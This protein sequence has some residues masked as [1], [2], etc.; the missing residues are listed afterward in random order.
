MEQ[1]LSLD[2]PLWTWCTA[3]QERKLAKIGAIDKLSLEQ[4]QV[5]TTSRSMSL[6]CSY[7]DSTIAVCS[8]QGIG[9]QYTFSTSMTVTVTSTCAAD[10]A[11][12]IVAASTGATATAT[13]ASATATGSSGSASSSNP[14]MPQVTARAGWLIGGAAVAVG[15]AIV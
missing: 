10:A 8:E 9:N 12:S 15:L 2:H 11:T 14:A 4:R 3:I 6:G 7:T 5:L 13:T 1:L